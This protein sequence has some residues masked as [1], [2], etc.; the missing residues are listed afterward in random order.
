MQHACRL[1]AHAPQLAFDVEQAAEVAA[2][3]RIGAGG[4]RVRA[5]ALGN[6]CR[7]VAELDR[8]VPPKPQQAS[9]SFISFSSRPGT[10]AS[11]FGAAP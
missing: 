2:D 4:K 10:I 5:L 6:G 11:S 3:D 1:V 9:D 7:D 8:K